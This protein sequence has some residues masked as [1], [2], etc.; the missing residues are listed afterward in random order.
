M[1]PKLVE[2][3]KYEAED[4]GIAWITFNRPERRNALMGNSQENSTVAKV[5][6]Y[7]RAA[8]DDPEVR[9]IVLTGE[10][11]GF[12]SGADMRRDNDPSVLGENFAGNRDHTE[13]PDFIRQHFFHGFTQLHRDISLIRKPTIAMING[14][15]VGSGMDMALHC[16]IRVGCEN[17]QFV[18]YHQLGQIFENGGSY[19]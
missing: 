1:G 11:Q 4:T 12:C 5:G 3:L 14:A 9:V 19:Y 8:D 10:G 2:Y 18:G 16:D 6:E 13:S 17:T 7:M 15:A